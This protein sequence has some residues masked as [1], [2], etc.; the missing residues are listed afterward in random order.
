MRSLF[1]FLAVLMVAAC[2]DKPAPLGPPIVVPAGPGLSAAQIREALVGNTGTGAMSG[3][4]ITYTMYLA[5]DG[6]AQAKLPTGI[7]DGKW[8]ITD[9][10]QICL[11]WRVFRNG[12]EFCQAV[13]KEADFYKLVNNNSVEILSFVPGKRI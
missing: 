13:Y 6:T 5:P 3:S 4:S 11:V 9:T 8:R 2:A 12:Q 10:G 7:D 1:A